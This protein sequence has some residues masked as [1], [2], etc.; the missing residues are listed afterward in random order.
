M[1]P[2]NKN[3]SQCFSSHVIDARSCVES[4]QGIKSRESLRVFLFVSSF[5]F[6]F[7]FFFPTIGLPSCLDYY[8]E[9]C[10]FSAD[11]KAETQSFGMSGGF[12]IFCLFVEMVGF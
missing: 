11:L 3:K 7:G 6:F 10:V 2:Q 1:D 5:F 9:R 12:W 8:L 4:Q